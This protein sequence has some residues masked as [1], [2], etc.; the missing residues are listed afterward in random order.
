M[1]LALCGLGR[2]GLQLAG[3]VVQKP[4]HTLEMAFCRDGS[5]RAGKTI[6]DVFPYKG[7]SAPI[8]E[9][10]D[11]EHVFSE[12]KPDVLIDFS[13]RAATMQLLPV[14]ARYG[15]K[16]VVCTTDFTERQF[17]T[18]RDTA[19]NTPGFSLVLAPNVTLGVN[20]LMML[21]EQVARCLPEYDFAI[22]EKHHNKK[23]DVSAT[24]RKLADGISNILK[25]PVPLNSIR[26]GGYVG[27]HEVM[28]V[29]EYE[30]ITLIH[31][32]FS[33]QAFASGALLAADFARTRD[34]FFEMRDVV[35]SY[36]FGS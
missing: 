28:A 27:L 14:C 29:G 8:Y 11:A 4:E 24:A 13:N 35:N 1:N 21:C 9:V 33:R 2:A 31:E 30:R 36:F 18:M 22:T 16:I 34:G 7:F 26:A 5:K 25:R 12:R 19:A 23:K 3:L 15:V 32:A 20:V 6:S 10:S 17:A